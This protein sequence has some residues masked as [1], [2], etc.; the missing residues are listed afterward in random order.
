MYQ[1]CISK[2][3][4]GCS[5]VMMG[6]YH[7]VWSYLCFWSLLQLAPLTHIAPSPSP[8]VAHILIHSQDFYH[9]L[10]TGGFPIISLAQISSVSETSLDEGLPFSLSF[11]VLSLFAIAVALPI[12]TLNLSIC[13][14]HMMHDFA[15]SIKITKGSSWYW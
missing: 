10:L 11:L 2:H 13:F 1:R 8:L 9:S 5:S 7:V 15:W 3:S 6:H 14:S 4:A 12:R